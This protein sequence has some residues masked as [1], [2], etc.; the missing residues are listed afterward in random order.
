MVIVYSRQYAENFSSVD[1]QARDWH[2]ANREMTV[3]FHI[4]KNITGDFTFHFVAHRKW[5]D[6]PNAAKS[7][8]ARP[9]SEEEAKHSSDIL[10]E[11][12]VQGTAYWNVSKAWSWTACF[13]LY[14][15]ED[16]H[17]MKSCPCSF[18]KSSNLTGTES[19]RGNAPAASRRLQG[20]ERSYSLLMLSSKHFQRRLLWADIFRC[21]TFM[22][23]KI[24]Q[25]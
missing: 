25:A 17:K 10:P 19:K 8:S 16:A 21:W 14:F 5:W 1:L 20:N 12:G 22:V 3:F 2:P 18:G 15:H 4:Y 7:S 11:T 6:L 13:W 23:E 9:C 24:R